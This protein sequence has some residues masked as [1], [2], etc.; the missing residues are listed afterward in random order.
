MEKVAHMSEGI[1][2][3]YKADH[4]KKKEDCLPNEENGSIRHHKQEEI[5]TVKDTRTDT[6]STETKKIQHSQKRNDTNQNDRMAKKCRLSSDDSNEHVKTLPSSII[7]S[8]NQTV[9]HLGRKTDGRKLTQSYRNTEE[10]SEAKMFLR[11]LGDFV[12]VEHEN[13]Q[14]ISDLDAS[15]KFNKADM[16]VEFPFSNPDQ[17]RCLI[18]IAD[19]LVGDGSADGKKRAK[20]IAAENAFSL[21]KDSFPVVKKMALGKDEFKT[22]CIQL[23]KITNPAVQTVSDEALPESNKGHM[24][25]QKMGWKGGGL[26]KKEHGRTEPIQVKERQFRAGLGIDLT[27]YQDAKGRLLSDRMDDTIV[28]SLLMQVANGEREYLVFSSS[29]SNIQRKRIHTKSRRIGL[30]SQ[31]YGKGDDR[32]LT[33][34]CKMDKNSILE[35]AQSGSQLFTIQSPVGISK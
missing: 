32:Y 21:L 17:V 23:E 24:L 20:Q 9:N 3:S 4:P 34:R 33:I 5:G 22:D 2:V 14:P 29:L 13:S 1:E 19:V 26:G 30:K 16:R 25:L 15:A 28:N 8:G 12:V 31:S 35:S 7:S 6:N 10:Q 18:Y 27:K 11:G